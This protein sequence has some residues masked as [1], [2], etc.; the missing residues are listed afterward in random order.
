MV[1]IL[2]L[3]ML[4][5]YYVPFYVVTHSPHSRLILIS[6][7]HF[8][9][10]LLPLDRRQSLATSVSDSERDIDKALATNKFKDQK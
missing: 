7:S 10:A 2:L 5:L 4:V 6:W 8:V 1:L 9:D 3:L